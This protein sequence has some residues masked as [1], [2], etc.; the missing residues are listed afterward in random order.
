MADEVVLL[1]TW[2]SMFGMRVRLALAEKGVN[3]DYK[4]QDIENKSPLLLQMNPIHKKIPVLIHNGRIICE[5]AIIVQYIDEVWNDKSPFMP[6]DPYER[7]EARF[8]VDFIDKKTY[9]T[10]RKMWLSEGEEHEASKK[11]LI[12]I[13]KQLEDVL[14]DKTFYGG[15]TFGFLDIALITFSRW[16]YTYETYGNFKMEVECPKLMA[17]VKRCFQRETV[18][19]TLPDDKKVYDYVFAWE[20]R[21]KNNK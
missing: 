19:K 7:A 5:S 3:Y 6:S 17:W 18:S 13:F 11:E 14:G 20:K 10:W 21:L 8:W 12:S 9:V 1:D 15:D 4:E 16:F 2:A